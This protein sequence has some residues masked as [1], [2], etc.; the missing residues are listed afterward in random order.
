MNQ[1]LLTV[2]ATWSEGE[3]HPLDREGQQNGHIET[4]TK[5]FSFEASDSNKAR[6]L[7]KKLLKKFAATLPTKNDDGRYFC[8]KPALSDINLAKMLKFKM[9]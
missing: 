2:T 7:A 9:V 3:Y 4:K 5:I 6:F 1:Y 8:T